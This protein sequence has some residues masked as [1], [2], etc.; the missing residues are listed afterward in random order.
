M[1][2]A[3]GLDPQGLLEIGLDE[4][5]WGELRSGSSAFVARHLGRVQLPMAE[6]TAAVA[7]LPLTPIRTGHL[8]DW[9]DIA[10]GRSTVL[11]Y[12]R[13][14]CRVPGLARPLLYDF[15]QTEDTALAGGD[16]LFLPGSVIDAGVR[17]RL[18][19]RRW[20]PEGMVR[21][22]GEGSLFVPYAETEW[23]G[24]RLPLTELHRRRM[25]AHF[26]DA[27]FHS[28]LL[29]R[30]E[31]RVTEVLLTLLRAAG[32]DSRALA[33]VFDRIVHRDGTV[34]RFKPA[35]DES[36]YRLG[37]VTYPTAEALVAASLLPARAAVTAERF[38]VADA[39]PPLHAP[40]LSVDAVTLLYAVLGTHREPGQPPVCGDFDVHVQWGALAMGGY[41]PQRRGYFFSGAKKTKWMYEAVVRDLPWAAPLLFVIAPTAPFLLWPS[42]REPRD[43]ELVEDL[44]TRVRTAISAWPERVDRTAPEIQRVVAEW[45]AAGGSELSAAFRRQIRWGDRLSPDGRP[46]PAGEPVEPAGFAT[47]TMSQACQVVGALVEAVA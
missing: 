2:T 18:P 4:E 47:L 9:G 6:L 23:D 45:L 38:T 27:S 46:L 43:V 21:H 19:L 12:N 44:L 16:T 25:R 28:D 41:P 29:T 31:D 13:V 17:G 34:E 1:T 39:A 14:V 33:F 3:L 36:G 22:D 15:N 26:P 30:E 5:A 35:L 42:S 10:S 20:S 37:P 32:P 40:L 24:E 8:A 7:A 11:D